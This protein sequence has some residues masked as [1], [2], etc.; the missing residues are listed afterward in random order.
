M[1]VINK[2]KNS[3]SGKALVSGLLVMVL[4]AAS[5]VNFV[6]YQPKSLKEVREVKGYS[7]Q[8]DSAFDLPT[9]RYAK[10]LG[11][12]QTLNSKKFTFQTD[13]TPEEVYVFY[14]NILS[15]D[16]WELKKV[17]NT[18]DFYTA[19][20]KKGKLFIT[21]WATYDKDTK[22]TFASVEIVEEE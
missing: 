17:G 7:T 20:F 9:P 13:K 15:V 16:D 3:P 4:F 21:M 22:L 11:Y 1:E 10:S 6:Q 18:D 8:I 12:D 5:Y 14:D 2:L 19:E